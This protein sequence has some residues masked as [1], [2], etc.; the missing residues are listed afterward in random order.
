VSTAVSPPPTTTTTAAASAT[1]TSA[2]VS[3]TNSQSGSQERVSRKFSNPYPPPSITSPSPKL[4]PGRA[5]SP[6]QQKHQQKQQQQQKQNQ[7]HQQQLP[8][9]HSV[10]QITEMK[11]LVMPE[12]H[13]HHSLHNNAVARA[14]EVLVN[15]QIRKSL[16]LTVL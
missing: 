11:S 2:A 5:S 7:Q 8:V 16:S 10:D 3:T 14:S 15:K 13:G 9:E 4:L 1:A 6:L 12:E